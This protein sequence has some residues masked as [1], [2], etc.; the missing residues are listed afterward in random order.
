MSAIINSIH[1]EFLKLKRT[2]SPWLCFLAPAISVTLGAFVV[3]GGVMNAAEGGE[4]QWKIYCEIIFSVW[5]KFILP[6]Y[7]TLQLALMLGIEN[8]GRQWKQL[9][10]L[11]LHR[12][13]HYFSKLACAFFLIGISNLIVI[14]LI[15]ASG[16][17]VSIY[18]DSL[19]GSISHMPVSY[20][21]LTAIKI[22]VG[23]L[24]LI[25]LQS[26]ISFKSLNYNLA[27]GVGFVAIAFC[28]FLPG[29]DLWIIQYIPWNMPGTLV[30]VWGD[31]AI[32]I[33][34]V[35]VV[36]FLIFLLAGMK[37]FVT[38]EWG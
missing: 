18:D 22:T 26:Y 8:N 2:L 37:S 10:S 17:I 19:L 38:R 20:A 25:S 3:F 12:G 5:T 36:G 4:A 31:E 9:M 16:F 23:S 35:G 28:I 30:K 6:A 15:P 33:M 32:T 34:V 24:F 13:V 11:P 7:I 1:A 21:V 14:C 29:K 27:I